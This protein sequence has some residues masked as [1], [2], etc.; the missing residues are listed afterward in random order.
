L[1]RNFEFLGSEFQNG[2][3]RGCFRYAKSGISKLAHIELKDK[4]QLRKSTA[5][6]KGKK[7]IKETETN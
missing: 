3:E 1:G 4:P 5:N 6:Q 7:K 2:R